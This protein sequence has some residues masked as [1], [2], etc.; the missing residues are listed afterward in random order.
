MTIGN[1]NTPLSKMDRSS[2]QKINTEIMDL[3]YKLDK[4]DL[5]DIYMYTTFRSTAG[6]YTFFSTT[7][8]TFSKI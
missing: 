3:N 8:R 1:L 2:R 5:T 7:C 6:E 4:T